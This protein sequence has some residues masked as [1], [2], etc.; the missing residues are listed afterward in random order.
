MFLLCYT[1]VLT[2]C[3]CKQNSFFIKTDSSSYQ[4]LHFRS[5]KS[6]SFKILTTSDAKHCCHKLVHLVSKNLVS[7]SWIYFLIPAYEADVLTDNVIT[8]I[9]LDS[10][11]LR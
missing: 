7:E 10:T 11:A 6:T 8:M 4:H 5:L 3:V 1:F 2:D 9:F